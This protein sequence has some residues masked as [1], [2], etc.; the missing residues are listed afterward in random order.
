MK[1]II[2]YK[3]QMTQKYREDGTVVPVTVVKADRCVITQVKSQDTDGYHSVQLGIGERKN[4]GKSRQGHIKQFLVE[5][6]KNFADVKEVRLQ[7]SSQFKVGDAIT[8]NTFAAGDTVSATGTSKGKGFQG[9]VKRHGFAGSPASHGH[10]D[11]LRMPGSIGAQDAQRVYKGTR[12]GGRMGGDRVTVKNLEIV[13]VD[14][15]G[16]LLFVKGALPGARNSLVMILGEGEATVSG[17]VFEK[18]APKEEAKTE[19]VVTEEKAAEE[20]PKEDTKPQEETKE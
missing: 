13:D 15:E 6:Q 10:K 17:N 2:G 4:A 18:P 20:Q 11:Q 5:G 8:V 9:V 16:Q 7:D 1:F 14:A 19:E 12:M 3:Q